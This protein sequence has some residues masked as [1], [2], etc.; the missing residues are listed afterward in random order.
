MRFITK[1]LL[2]FALNTILLM[3]CQP[4]AE[5]QTRR[6]ISLYTSDTSSR[7]FVRFDGKVNFNFKGIDG[8]PYCISMADTIP[9]LPYTIPHLLLYQG[10]PLYLHSIVSLE[11]T[12]R[13]GDDSLNAII[14]VVDNKGDAH[15]TRGNTNNILRATP[16]QIGIQTTLAGD[17]SKGAYYGFT[18]N[19]IDL[20][21]GEGNDFSSSYVL[22]NH[23]GMPG[24]VLTINSTADTALWANSV[25]SSSGGQKYFSPVNGQVVSIV[26]S[27]YNIINP[28]S[29]LPSLAITLPASPVDN[30][31]FEITFTQPVKAITYAGGKVA[32][33]AI[34]TAS[35]NGNYYKKFV[36][37][38][39]D[40]TW[41]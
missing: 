41:Y 9:T 11:N 23:R 34:K 10:D 33:N 32:N 22:T 3:G 17:T 14:G 19:G 13:T 12:S 30:D 31:W 26:K 21:R 35:P 8:M 36:F 6:E 2:F 5:H 37:R 39:A 29:A 1:R 20:M 4:K 16:N 24:Q 27:A 25:N 28:V 40:M 7:N 15:D 38:K 18:K